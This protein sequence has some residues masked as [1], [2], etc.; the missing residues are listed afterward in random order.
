M[1]PKMA[2]ILS[3]WRN[4]GYG[5]NRKGSPNHWIMCCLRIDC[6]LVRDWFGIG[7]EFRSQTL[8]PTEL[9]AHAVESVLYRR[10]RNSA[11]PKI[12]SGTQN[13]TKNDL[14]E[15][16]DSACNIR[17]SVSKPIPTLLTC[18][19]LSTLYDSESLRTR[20]HL[21]P[22]D[23]IL[24]GHPYWGMTQQ[25]RYEMGFKPLFRQIRCKCRADVPRCHPWIPGRFT[26]FNPWLA[27]IGHRGT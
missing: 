18:L 2:K 6:G 22:F 17:H 27:A 9:R 16:I 8:Y 25:L 19:S 13:G 21:T 12:A 7:N 15:W 24:L 4:Y 23:V 20:F 26:R 1:V 5:Q 3:F 11:M 14:Y 10:R